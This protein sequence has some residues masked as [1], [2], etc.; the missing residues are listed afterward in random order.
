M[1][2][3]HHRTIALA[4]H[5]SE[6]QSSC[7][8]IISLFSCG[9]FAALRGSLT[10]SCF[11][12]FHPRPPCVPYQVTSPDDCP[13]ED[14]YIPDGFK[15]DNTLPEWREAGAAWKE[16]Y[17]GYRC[18]ASWGSVDGQPQGDPVV[19]NAPLDWPDC[20]ALCSDAN[21]ISTTTAA[22]C[23]GWSFHPATG[24]CQ[25]MSGVVLAYNSWTSWGVNG[26]VHG[27]PGYFE[28]PVTGC[29]T[30]DPN[31][32]CDNMNLGLL[33]PGVICAL[34][35][36][37]C[38]WCDCFFC[39]SRTS[40]RLRELLRDGQYKLRKA[41]CVEVSA[42]TRRVGDGKEKPRDTITYQGTFMTRDGSLF[43][44]SPASTAPLLGLACEQLMLRV[45]LSKQ[46]KPLADPAVA[47]RCQTP[48]GLRSQFALLVRNTAHNSGFASTSSIH[49]PGQ[50]VRSPCL[51][52]LLFVDGGQRER[53]L[54]QR[55]RH[56]RGQHR[57]LKNVRH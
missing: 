23:A 31:D 1:S 51:D 4:R 43:V 41:L 26:T 54:H 27:Y 42:T 45:L 50:D 21:A 9:F 49:C 30:R 44:V 33:T 14:P 29:W 48:Q 24:S 6:I 18:E 10:G 20:C 16:C 12:C 47:E 35:G 38:V 15:D 8:R 46:L 36:L 32:L 25:L 57:P 52:C 13:G 53:E 11:V 5:G 55:G 3:P 37:I 28:A 2:R 22:A 40:G 34:L 17:D 39:P 7:M 19:L 56:Q